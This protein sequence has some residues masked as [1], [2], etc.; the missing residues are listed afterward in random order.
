[1]KGQKEGSKLAC[2]CICVWVD[3]QTQEGKEGRRERKDGWMKNEGWRK[4]KK[5]TLCIWIEGKN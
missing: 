4:G 5:I 2:E 1:M 3:G